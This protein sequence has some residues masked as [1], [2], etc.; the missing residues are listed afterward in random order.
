MVNEFLGKIKRSPSIPCRLRD[1]YYQ[2]NSNGAAESEKCQ[3]NKATNTPAASISFLRIFIFSKLLRK[4]IV[5][6]LTKKK[7]KTG[8][9][10]QF[11]E[12]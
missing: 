2:N 1:K 8:A 3:T 12:V 7:E 10:R 11:A 9:A 6:C 5:R 4:N